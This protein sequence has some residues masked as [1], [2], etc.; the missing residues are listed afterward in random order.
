ML[1]FTSLDKWLLSRLTAGYQM[2][3]LSSPAGERAAKI[4]SVMAQ[5]NP[6]DR[7]LYLKSNVNPDEYRHILAVDTESP[8]PK[9]RVDPLKDA[10]VQIKAQGLNWHIIPASEVHKIPPVE[11][12]V[13]REIPMRGITML[14]GTSGV[15]KS[16]LA[17]D[18]AMNVAQDA[19]VLYGAFEGESGYPG[20]IAAWCKHNRKPAGKLFL[21]L[22]FVEM[23]NEQQLQNFISA[24]REINPVLVVIDTLA[25]SM[26]GADENST[27]DASLYVKMC[28][29]LMSELGCSI[30]LV[31]HTNKAG[32]VERGSVVLRASCDM[33]IRLNGS[34]DVIFKECSK[35]KDTEPFAPAAYKL[36]PLEVRVGNRVEHSAV[37]VP[38]E[39]VFQSELDPLTPNQAKVLEALALAVFES[40]GADTADIVESTGI[41]RGS[42]YR[43]FSRLMGL[44]FIRKMKRGKYSVTEAGRKKAGLPESKNDS[45]DSHDSHDSVDSLSTA[46]KLAKRPSQPS[47]PS[48]LNKLPGFEK[49]KPSA[50]EL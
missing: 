16:F 40:D 13:P 29:I 31:H 6:K 38:T 27:R 36:L 42:L 46:E 47:Q 25:M 17:L 18:Y 15:G 24:A 19:P 26:V 5:I 33:V 37:I 39:I 10:G 12:L 49:R 20:R 11:W 45:V 7:D 3:V 4:A 30:M 35:S 23:M 2:P 8:E 34:D 1:E 14:Y 28:K 32:F 50:L 43:I 41:Q 48:Q 22:G 44:G 21:C 9:P